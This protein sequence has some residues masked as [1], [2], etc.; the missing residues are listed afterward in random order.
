[1]H[2]NVVN[3]TKE[4]LKLTFNKISEGDY[5]VLIEKAE[6]KPEKKRRLLGYTSQGDIVKIGGIE[7]IVCW[8]SGDRVYCLTKEAVRDMEFGEHS[9]DFE[10]SDIRKWLNSEFYNMLVT[11]GVPKYQIWPIAIKQTAEDGTRNSKELFGSANCVSLLT[12][13]DYRLFRDV[14]TPIDGWWWTA[15]PYTKAKK[16][17]PIYKNDIC[18]INEYGSIEH[19]GFDAQPIA[20]RPYCA[21]SNELLI[22]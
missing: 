16:P 20:V 15:T 12:T 5:S 6:E 17:H 1:M 22:D 3:N 14:I 21:F 18:I 10:D 19:D 7:W 8:N 11:N 4:E 2:F 13:A 9:C